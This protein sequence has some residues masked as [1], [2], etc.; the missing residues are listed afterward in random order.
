MTDAETRITRARAIMLNREPFYGL[1]ATRLELVEAPERTPTMATDG[2][3]L[4]F[5]PAFVMSLSAAE[6]DFAIRHETEHVALEHTLRRGSRDP[7]GWNMAADYSV[8]GRL[9]AEGYGLLAGCLYCSDYSDWAVERIY[10]EISKPNFRKR[11]VS[12]NLTN[13]QPSTKAPGEDDVLEYSPGPGEKD[14]TGKPAPSP[15]ELRAEIRQAVQQAAA[16]ARAMGSLPAS[17]QRQLLQAE[18]SRRDYKSILRQWLLQV[19]RADY[20][21][22]RPSRRGLALGFLSPS[23]R[24]EASG[25]IVYAVDVS[26][27]M[28]NKILRSAWAEAR[29][30]QDQIKGE[31][32]VFYCD[33]E[34]CGEEHVQ[35]GESLPILAKFSGGGGTDF[36]PVFQEVE[37]RGIVPAA[38]VYFTDLEGRFPDSPP[39]FPVLWVT[40]RIPGASYPSP[41]FGSILPFLGA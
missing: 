23:L 34:L 33:A 35:E 18:A 24:S 7:V 15:A 9:Y 27:S 20:S 37:R 25:L 32:W 40:D 14:G 36:R 5:N 8:N 39:T 26:G 13:G 29:S 21:W 10:P 22:T 30:A 3:R 17:L 12:S 16:S 4:I 38:L 19:C 11:R 2:R 41:E 6:L 1:L 31:A 28:D